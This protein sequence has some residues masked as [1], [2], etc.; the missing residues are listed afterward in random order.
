MTTLHSVAIRQYLMINYI[1]FISFDI[2]I[3]SC[4]FV[5]DDD[6]MMVIMT[7]M[8]MMTQ[9]EKLRDPQSYYNSS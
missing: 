3:C 5:D 7:M 8:M 6:V 1:L 4:V 2:F 9:D